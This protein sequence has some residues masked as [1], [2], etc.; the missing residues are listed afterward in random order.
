MGDG[1]GADDGD[2]DSDGVLGG[3]GDGADG[4]LGV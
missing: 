3:G 2:R 1:G 4:S